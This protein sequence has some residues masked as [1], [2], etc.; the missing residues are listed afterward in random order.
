MSLVEPEGSA[1]IIRDKLACSAKGPIG[2]IPVL[3]LKDF[4][5]DDID[6]EILAK[7]VRAAGLYN[8]RQMKFE[9]R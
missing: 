5:A 2:L 1:F 4:S 3:R 8:D 9:K 6:D 7:M